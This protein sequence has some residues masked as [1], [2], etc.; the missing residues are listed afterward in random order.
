MGSTLSLKLRLCCMVRLPHTSFLT[1]SL[2]GLFAWC[3]SLHLEPFRSP[4]C[5]TKAGPKVSAC[6]ETRAESFQSVPAQQQGRTPQF[7]LV[8]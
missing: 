3:T 7:E 8:V 5:A 2:S 6:P 4:G 1:L